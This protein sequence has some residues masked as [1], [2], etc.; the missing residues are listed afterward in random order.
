[1][2]NVVIL[3]CFFSSLIIAAYISLWFYVAKKVE[4]RVDQLYYVEAPQFGVSFTSDNSR[5]GIA[6][7]PFWPYAGYKGDV[8]FPDGV[9]V[10]VRDMMIKPALFDKESFK[11]IFP[12]GLSIK[13]LPSSKY[14]SFD[15]VILDLK[16]NGGFPLGI[17]K[18][19]MQEWYDSDGRIEVKNIKIFKDSIRPLLVEAS[20]NMSFTPDL[21][22]FIEYNIRVVNPKDF[23]DYV[24]QDSG[25]PVPVK[26]VVS[27]LRPIVETDEKT[28]DFFI[29]TKFEIKNGTLSIGSVPFVPV[30][31]VEW[32]E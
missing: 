21:Q 24:F 13:E 27:M 30:P 7:F 28:G 9:S 26:K 20:G 23:V 11:I 8:T 2:R 12:E 6:G 3:T 22:P 14:I 17:K 4:Q 1:M 18:T 15:E 32:E 10:N 16:L 31:N 19:F 5:E 29:K 25:W